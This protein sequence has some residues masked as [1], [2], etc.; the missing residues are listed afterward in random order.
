[1]W[2]KRQTETSSARRSIMVDESRSV[3]MYDVL[4]HSLGPLLWALANVDAWSLRKTYKAALA[5]ELEKNVSDAE[6]IATPST[7]NGIIDGMGLVQRMNGNNKTF[8]QLSESV[9]SMVLYVGG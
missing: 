7:W 9:L 1:M 2:F 6:V 5:R 8:A 4:A 3:N